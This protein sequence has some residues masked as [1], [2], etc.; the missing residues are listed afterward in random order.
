M[1]SS[2]LPFIRELFQEAI[3]NPR[4]VIGG[5]NDNGGDSPLKAQ[6]TKHPWLGEL[7]SDVLW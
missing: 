7:G 3:D 6:G 5:G 2:Q 4:V 1:E